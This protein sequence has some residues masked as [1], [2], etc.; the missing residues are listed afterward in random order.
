[1]KI[2]VK[3]YL[4]YSS[5]FAIFTEGLFFNL[6]IDWKLLYLIILVNYVVLLKYYKTIKINIYFKYIVGFLFIHA[7][8]CYTIIGIPPN[9]MLSQLLGMSIVGVY[10]YN[11]VSIYKTEE[12][13]AVFLSIALFV[14]ILAYPLYFLN[15][16]PFKHHDNEFRLMSI[17]KEPAHYAVV[18]LPACYFYLKKRSYFRF[19]IIFGTLILT[20]STL[21]YLGCALMF[22]IPNLSL[23]R[24][25]YFIATIPIMVGIFYYVYSEYPF[26]KLRVDDTYETLNSVNTGKFKEYTNLTT[27][28]ILSNVFIAKE[29]FIEHPLGTGIGSHFYVYNTIYKKNMRPPEYLRIQNLHNSNSTDANS[30]FV[31]MVSEMGVFG[32]FLIAFLMYWAAKSFTLNSSELFFAQGVFIYLLLKLFRDGHYFTP[33]LYLFIWLLYFEIKL[34]LKTKESLLQE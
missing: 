26:L 3:N 31:R 21:G 30:L 7:A 10:F 2:N 33:E 14:A 16:H 11:F 29:N 24:I 22:I 6:I 1:L 25:G 13:I 15:F 4:L 9:Y 28:S 23:K 34:A 19:L 18:A 12:I 17:F 27:Y 8:I 5:V 20:N 32:L